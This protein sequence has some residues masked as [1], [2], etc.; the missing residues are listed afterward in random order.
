MEVRYVWQSLKA[1]RKLSRL[2][3]VYNRYMSILWNLLVFGV[4]G[5]VSDT[6]TTDLTQAGYV[7]ELIDPISSILNS[8]FLLAIYE[9]KDHRE[10]GGSPAS[11]FST[12]DF[13]EADPRAA[14]SPELPEFSQS[15]GGPIYSLPNHDPELFDP[16]PTAVQQ[17]REG[18]IGAESESEDQAQ[19][20]AQSNE[21]GE[22]SEQV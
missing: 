3:Y 21:V 15:F 13:V 10:R 8:R 1:S 9:S 14:V 7:I 18:E 6:T 12:V 5:T 4:I 22:G 19:A 2:L 17:E 20:Q 16:E 11:S